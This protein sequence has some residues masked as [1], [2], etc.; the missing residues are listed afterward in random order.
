MDSR[1]LF[2]RNTDLAVFAGT[3]LASFA[4]ALALPALGVPP[5]TPPWAWLL[6]VVA[7][8]VS[9]VW[10][11]VF[12]TYFDREELRRRPVLYAAAPLVAYGLGVAAHAHSSELFWRAL[13]YVAV[14][15]FIRQQVGWMVLY[16]HRAGSS[17]LELALDRAAIWA[18]T[19]GPVIW[20]HAHLPR[21]F[22]WFREQDFIDG[23]PAWAGTVA[24]DLHFFVLTLWVV[25]A[26]A[27]KR[28]HPGKALL[29]F[30]TWLSWFGG[31]VL[32]KS[33]LAF[34]VMNVALHGVPY[35]ALLFR[36][37]RHREGEH[38]YGPLVAALG[39]NLAGF[40]LF[41]WAVAFFEEFAWDRLV[42]HDHPMFF[43][44]GSLELEG[45]VLALV[46]PLLALPQTTHYLLDG[47]VWRTRDD[48]Q[49]AYRLGWKTRAA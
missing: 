28:F 35:L 41:L 6:L 12:R 20:W 18:A 38:G 8:D 9:H 7:L 48:P 40:L 24:L 21:P 11:T 33:D 45:A 47:F 2:S 17:R 49:L 13:A 5:E 19:L 39:R 23:L 46:V 30:A 26:L 25:Q 34:T 3:A 42:W 10:S 27:F 4:L 14:W 43:G 37:A 22:W 1:W 31:I 15:H 16:G 29:L 44:D 32:A 36:Y